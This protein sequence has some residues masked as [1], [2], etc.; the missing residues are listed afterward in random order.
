[1]TIPL[2][3]TKVPGRPRGIAPGLPGRSGP[4]RASPKNGHEADMSGRPLG[5]RTKGRITSIPRRGFGAWVEWEDH[6]DFVVVFASDFKAPPLQ[7]VFLE[8]GRV[9]K[10]TSGDV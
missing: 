8:P 5:A 2:R 3:A 7:A 9:V 10:P 6:E 4:L 1:M